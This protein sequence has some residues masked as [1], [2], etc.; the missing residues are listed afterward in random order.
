MS[1]VTFPSV[2]FVPVQTVRL[3]D[4]FKALLGGNQKSW[5]TGNAET[6]H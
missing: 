2:P 5:E 3:R 4:H 1:D 6:T